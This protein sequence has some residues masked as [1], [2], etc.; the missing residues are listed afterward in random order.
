MKTI[1][2]SLKSLHFMKKD[3]SYFKKGMGSWVWLSC[4]TFTLLGALACSKKAGESEAPQAQVPDFNQTKTLSAEIAPVWYEAVGVTEPVEKATVTARVT[5]QVL[6]TMKEEGARVL[7]GETILVLDSRD[8]ASRTAQAQQGLAA[9][10]ATLE[11]ARLNL[12]RTRKLHN[13]SAATDAMLEAAQS[14]FLQA[15]AGLGIAQSQ[16]SDAETYLSYHEVVAPFD[17]VMSKRWVK[18]GD[19]AWPGKPLAEIYNPENMELELDL[20]ERLKSLASQ[21]AS[22]RFAAPSLD[23]EGESELLE[24]LPAVDPVSRTFRLKLKLPQ[25]EGLSSGLFARGWLKTGTRPVLK[26]PQAAVLQVGQ[27]S[28]V[29]TQDPSGNWEKRWVTLGKEE[30]TQI[31]VLSGLE[32]GE[33]IGWVE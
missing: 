17:G 3:T 6:E 19:M 9:A 28:M 15:E 14:A 25:H 23:W 13:Q 22:M 27:L 31:E 1:K 5:G 16:L 30:G 11:E 2:R 24:A 18:S 10:K 21:A 4:C 8:A 33:T 29:W 7:A 26:V 32:S 12:E 20:P